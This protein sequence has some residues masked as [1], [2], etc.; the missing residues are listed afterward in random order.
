M[1]NDAIDTS[2]AKWD[3]SKEERYAIRWFAENGYTGRIVKQ[4]I[5][6]TVFEISKDGVTSKFEIPQGIDLKNVK[7]YMEQYRK[8]WKVLCELQDLRNQMKS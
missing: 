7:K 3:F 5:S 6:K 4:Y 1:K 2:N 8:N